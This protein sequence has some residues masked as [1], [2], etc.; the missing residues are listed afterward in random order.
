MFMLPNK[1]I[2]PSRNIC[3]YIKYILAIKI[4]MTYFLFYFILFIYI[5]KLNEM[6]HLLVY[7]EQESKE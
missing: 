5:F 7:R 2:P 3:F 1:T 4:Q 6:W